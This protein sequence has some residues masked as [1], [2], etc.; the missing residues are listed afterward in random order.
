MENLIK[1]W[2]E[3][4]DPRTKEK[5]EFEKAQTNFS[6]ALAPYIEKFRTIEDDHLVQ[7]VEWNKWQANPDNK[8]DRY[9]S[10]NKRVLSLVQSD[11]GLTFQLLYSSKRK[12]SRTEEKGFRADF[13]A[14]KFKIDGTGM[15]VGDINIKDQ[16]SSAKELKD[17]GDDIFLSKSYFKIDDLKD[18]TT[19][20]N[21]A[22]GLLTVDIPAQK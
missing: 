14:I 12:N 16:S 1:K 11:Q 2:F 8:V 17:I 20:L 5:R 6:S 22:T 13:F 7:V 21:R 15:P 9:V 10:I 18:I 4:N 3:G 19:V